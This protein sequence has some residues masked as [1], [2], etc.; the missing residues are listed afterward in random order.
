MTKKYGKRIDGTDKDVGYLGEIRMPD[1][2]DV[3]TEMSVGMPGTRETFRPAVT[4][5]MHPADINYMRETG[6][7]PEDVIATSKRH[8]KKRKAEGKSPFYSSKEKKMNKGGTVRGHGCEKKGKT[9]G[10]IV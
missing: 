2:R 10:R 7:V 1:G 5:G 3:M 9:R 4:P 8:A 6:E